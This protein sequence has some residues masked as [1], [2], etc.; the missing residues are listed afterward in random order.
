[1]PCEKRHEDKS[2]LLHDIDMEDEQNATQNM[3]IFFNEL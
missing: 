2:I 3:H 1:M